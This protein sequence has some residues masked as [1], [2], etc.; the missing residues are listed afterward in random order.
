LGRQYFADAGGVFDLP[1]DFPNDLVHCFGLEAAALSGAEASRQGARR[2]QIEEKGQAQ[3]AD[4]P[5]SAAP[6]VLPAANGCGVSSV[7]GSAVAA[8]GSSVVCADTRSVAALGFVFGPTGTGPPSCRPPP[9][10]SS[11]PRP[12]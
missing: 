3:G 10:S 11:F 7:A 1:E 12:G 2:A 6:A 9:P 5:S 4:G 8:A